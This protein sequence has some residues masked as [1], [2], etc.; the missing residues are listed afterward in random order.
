MP[1]AASGV[2]PVWPTNTEVAMD[3]M[4]SAT[5]VSR[6]GSV[7]SRMAGSL[8]FNSQP[9]RLG[10]DEGVGGLVGPCPVPA[11]GASGSPPFL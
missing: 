4:G 6:A 9:G 7:S 1:S 11:S 2:G 3:S 8:G 10:R 5:S